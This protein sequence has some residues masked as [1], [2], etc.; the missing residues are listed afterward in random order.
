MPLRRIFPASLLFACVIAVSGRAQETGTTPPSAASPADP[1]PDAAPGKDKTY[2]IGGDV[3]PPVVLHKDEVLFT[4]EE[5][6]QKFT[7]TAVVSITVDAQ[8][9]PQDVRLVK[10]AAAGVKD[11]KKRAAAELLDPKAVASVQGY[12]FKPA[13]HNGEPVPVKMYVEVDFQIF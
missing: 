2:R 13:M 5:R 12:R 4:K 6:R 3:T 9:M 8:G 7:G 1:K 10:S 11:P